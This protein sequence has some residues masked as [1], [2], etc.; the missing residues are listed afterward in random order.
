VVK[1]LA[2]VGAGPKAAAIVARCNVL[3]ALGHQNV[4]NVTV[5][6]GNAIGSAWSG[7]GGFSSGFLRLCTPGEKDVGFPYAEVEPWG[8]LSGAV[9]PALFSR[10]SWSAFLV[11][12]GRISDWVDRG[13]HYPNHGLWAQYL[14]WVFSTAGKTFV[15]C[16]V[17][18]VRWTPD[19]QWE[20]RY[21]EEG[22]QRSG[23]FDGVVLTGA[24]RSRLV[25]ASPEISKDQIF[26][27]ETFWPRRNSITPKSDDGTTVAVIGAGGAAGAIVA[28]L[29]EKFAEEPDFK[30]YS[31]NPTGT[32]FP[33][34]DGHAERRWFSDPSEWLELSLDDRADLLKRTEGGVI[35]LR[36]KNI[37]DQSNIISYKKGKAI[38]A[39]ASSG[40]IKLHID[41]R[42]TLDK[43]LHADYMI[44]AIG[45]DPF[46]LFDLLD[47]K[48]PLLNEK[49]RDREAVRHGM[50]DDLS[51]PEFFGF[52][53][54]L[55]IPSL[56][57]LAQGP[58]MGN[59]GCLGLMSKRVVAPYL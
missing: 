6:E 12:T 49:N 23:L 27:S 53:P 26:D 24:G 44:N 58:G 1:E 33:R 38:F 31:I 18:K 19:K 55:H 29:A 51:V 21:N 28:W 50:Q 32:L 25:S 30:I 36:N 22:N 15:R 47:S 35:S 59:L 54:G 4:P 43:T 7:G 52:G 5:F 20:I 8:P 2:I 48:H 9:S 46:G 40:E 41:Y 37:I 34:G 3:T 13:R 10:F 11:A 45:F 56:C 42:G 17:D 14:Q 39:E 16:S 57:D